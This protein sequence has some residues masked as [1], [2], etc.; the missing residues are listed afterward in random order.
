MILKYRRNSSL[1]FTISSAN[2][3]LKALVYIQLFNQG[4]THSTREYFEKR[5]NKKN[6]TLNSCISKARANSESKLTFSES[7]FNFLQKTLFFARSIYMDTRQGGP[8]PYN[9]RCR[10]QRLAGLRELTHTLLF[11]FT[12]C[13]VVFFRKYMICQ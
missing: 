6:A 5:V 10:C 8:S 3:L 9:P 7:S 2:I 13:F 4:L 1:S 12:F 11:C